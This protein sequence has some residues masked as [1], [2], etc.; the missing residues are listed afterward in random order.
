[1]DIKDIPADRQIIT[2][3]SL[4]FS[5][6]AVFR[7]WS[8]PALLKQ[9]WGPNGFTNTF[10]EFDFR[11]GGR[12]RFIMHGPEKGNY[13]NDVEFVEINPPEAITWKRHSKPLFHVAVHFQELSANETHVVFR[14]IFDTV[15]ACEKLRPYVTDK[16]EENF[17]RLTAVLAN[18]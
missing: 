9:W 11:V 2:Q 15:E 8:D 17:D 4:P 1:M 5:Q 12:W 6:E 13:P 10:Y 16:N 18:I 14:Q 7:A 3:R